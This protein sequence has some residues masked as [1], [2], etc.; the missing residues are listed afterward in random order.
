MSQTVK[1]TFDAKRQELRLDEPLHG[2]A[3][4]ER[5]SIVVSPFAD[6]AAPSNLPDAARSDLPDDGRPRVAVNLDAALELL[7]TFRSDDER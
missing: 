5:V 4:G 7:R 1:A 6:D 3:H 2:V